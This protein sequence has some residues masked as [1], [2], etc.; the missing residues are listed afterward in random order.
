[1]DIVRTILSDILGAFAGL[2]LGMLCGFGIGCIGMPPD[3]TAGDGLAGLIFVMMVGAG[4]AALAGFSLG[5]C[6]PS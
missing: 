1:M 4:F 2:I 3:P 5:L 6:V